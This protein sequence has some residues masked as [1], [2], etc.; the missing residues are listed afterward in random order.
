MT[1]II[2]HI[3]KPDEIIV[4]YSFFAGYTKGGTQIQGFNSA[5]LNN[6][7]YNA[8][9]TLVHNTFVHVTAVASNVAGLQGISYSEPILV[10][11]TPPDIVHV[12]D[13][14]LSS[15]FNLL[16]IAYKYKVERLSVI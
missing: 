14:D 10:D 16:K 11:L 1:L 9:V 2:H 12:F 5:G 8:N 15:K 4:F 6:F 13:G 3:H 7:A